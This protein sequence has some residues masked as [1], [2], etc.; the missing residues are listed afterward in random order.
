MARAGRT[1]G[2]IWSVMQ[3]HRDRPMKQEGVAGGRPRA[4]GSS[5]SFQSGTLTNN[6]SSTT[7]WR[8][9]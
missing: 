9:Q 6:L 3:L 2:P 1:G 4:K 8:V 5:V 7:V